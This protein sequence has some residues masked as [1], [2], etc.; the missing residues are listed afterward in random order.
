MSL[1]RDT[2][3]RS[4]V[5]VHEVAKFGV[6]GLIGFVVQLSVQNALHSGA[7]VGAIT[8]VIIGPRTPEQLGDLLAGADVVLG[9]EVLDR[10]DE[11]APPGTDAGPNDVAYTPPAISSVSLPASPAGRR[12][13]RRL[14]DAEAAHGA[15]SL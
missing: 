8:S 12:A 10:I 9:D 3:L 5:L 14:N 6:V 7:G 13:V 1:I 4:Q 11:I 2:Y 15:F